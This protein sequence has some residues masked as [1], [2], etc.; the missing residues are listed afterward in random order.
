VKF[1]FAPIGIAA[2]LAAGFAAQK[3][4]EGLWG[5]IDDEEAPE[6]EHRQVSFP[7]LLT[8]L[9]IEGALFRIAKGTVD[10]STR[11]GFARLTGVWPGDERPERE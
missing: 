7:K 11:A 3:A 5:L 9:A 1:L 4:F 8:A 10:H 2:G 6:P